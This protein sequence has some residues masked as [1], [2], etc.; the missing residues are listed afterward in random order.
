MAWAK[1][2]PASPTGTADLV[3]KFQ[4]SEPAPFTISIARIAA[5]GMMASAAAPYVAPVIT[6]P[7][8]RRVAGEA[9]RR[10]RSRRRS[11]AR[12][13]RSASGRRRSRGR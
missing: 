11:R 13:A 1:P 5:S 2:P 3:K 4:S 10:P 6:A 9:I 7:T 12:R 8:I